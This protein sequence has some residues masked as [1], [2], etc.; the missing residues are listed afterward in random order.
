MLD[1]G[2][3]SVNVIHAH[4]A[5]RNITMTVY[6]HKAVEGWGTFKKKF[7]R[8]VKDYY[9]INMGLFFTTEPKHQY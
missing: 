8:T 9:W 5:L 2:K 1:L 3:T 6:Q 4:E 7:W